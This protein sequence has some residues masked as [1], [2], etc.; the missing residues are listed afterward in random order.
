[1]Y[2]GAMETLW[3]N[4]HSNSNILRNNIG[5]SELRLCPTGRRIYFATPVL[6][7]GENVDRRSEHYDLPRATVIQYSW[8]INRAPAD[9][10]SLVKAVHE[11][12]ESVSVVSAYPTATAGTIKGVDTAKAVFNDLDAEILLLYDGSRYPSTHIVVVEKVDGVTFAFTGISGSESS[13]HADK[14]GGTWGVDCWLT[15]CDKNTNGMEVSKV[16]NFSGD[17]FTMHSVGTEVNAK[18]CSKRLHISVL[19]A[20]VPLGYDKRSKETISS[21]I[22]DGIDWVMPNLAAAMRLA[23]MYGHIERLGGLSLSQPQTSI[24]G[25]DRLPNMGLSGEDGLTSSGGDQIS[26]K[27]ACSYIASD[28]RIADISVSHSSPHSYNPA[29]LF[30]SYS[31]E[32]SRRQQGT[33]SARCAWNIGTNRNVSANEGALQEDFP[34]SLCP[35]LESTRNKDYALTVYRNGAM[36]GIFSD[37]TV[38][39]LAPGLEV[40]FI[41]T[42]YI[43]RPT[44]HYRYSLFDLRLDFA[45]HA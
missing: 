30:D 43:D 9:V 5:T 38:I 15:D 11:Q 31:K 35:V 20:M 7:S 36:H 2:L 24:G 22:P 33:E 25:L 13:A 23:L 42:T 3:P 10:I 37:Y 17:I 29:D 39:D 41:I 1:M 32:R 14:G 18:K 27:Q 40:R 26:Q 21:M 34:G 8:P 44:F 19:E 12:S 28:I 6:F 4:T 45:R 16:L